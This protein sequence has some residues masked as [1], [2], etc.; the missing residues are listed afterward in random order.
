MNEESHEFL[1]IE[2]AALRDEMKL[3]LQQMGEMYNFC[4][5]SVAATISWL[6]SIL[7]SLPW[8]ASLIAAWIPFAIVHYFA[9][10][11]KDHSN[12]IHTLGDYLQKL[13]DALAAPGFGWQRSVRLE[14]GR[15]VKMYYRTAHVFVYLRLSTILF[16][17]YVPLSKCDWREAIAHGASLLGQHFAR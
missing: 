4:F 6:L 3:K 11:R 9:E 12:S 14:N 5:I 10:Y 8:I 17:L 16:G 13:E 7:G 15:R 2:Y 1:K